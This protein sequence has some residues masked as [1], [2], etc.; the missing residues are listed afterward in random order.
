[1][2][3]MTEID[4][5]GEGRLRK[6]HSRYKRRYEIMPITTTRS[7]AF[8]PQFTRVSSCRI[9]SRPVGVT[10]AKTREFIM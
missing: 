5:F 4:G 2:Y 10:K 7:F 9:R 8:L 6:H 3:D 1:M